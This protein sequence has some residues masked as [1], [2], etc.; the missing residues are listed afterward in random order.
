MNI[1]YPSVGR[2][3]SWWTKS[4]LTLK[5]TG[6]EEYKTSTGIGGRCV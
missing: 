5:E 2:D 4:S 6:R 3:T 1:E